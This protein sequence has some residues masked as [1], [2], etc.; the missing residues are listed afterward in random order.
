LRRDADVEEGHCQDQADGVGA[1]VGFEEELVL[2]GQVMVSCLGAFGQAGGA[3][4]VVELGH[5]CGGGGG[6]IE[7]M[8]GG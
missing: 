4:G 3:R 7:A 2:G 8:P 6:V 5:C 1:W